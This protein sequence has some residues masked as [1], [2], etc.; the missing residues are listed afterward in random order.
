MAWAS[1]TL[2]SPI[3]L[4]PE[5]KHL[6]TCQQMRPTKPFNRVSL[7]WLLGIEMFRF[8]EQ[9]AWCAIR[10][11]GVTM[12]ER[13]GRS[14]STLSKAFL[15]PWQLKHIWPSW[16]LA[17]LVY[18]EKENFWGV[19]GCSRKRVLSSLN[20]LL[21]WWSVFSSSSKQKLNSVPLSRYI[22]TFGFICWNLRILDSDH[23]KE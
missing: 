11:V 23:W 15:L 6:I 8:R 3:K 7:A 18:G 17:L 2:P 9:S 13:V 22:P 1:P 14:W 5:P 16:L 10:Q 12:I 21:S 19:V 20:K 4:Q